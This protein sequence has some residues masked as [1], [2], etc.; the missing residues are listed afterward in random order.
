M[1]QNNLPW[2]VAWLTEAT[3]IDD[4]FVLAP[5]FKDLPAAAAELKTQGLKMIP[6]INAHLVSE[7]FKDKYFNEA[8]NSDALVKSSINPEYENGK[9]TN[10][11][12]FNKIV[13][14]DFFGKS[15]KS[16][17]QE[18]IDDFQQI[19]P[20]DGVFVDR[21][22]GL[23]GSCQGECPVNKTKVVTEGEINDEP[24]INMGWWSGFKD[25]S[26]K[27]TYFLPYVPGGWIGGNVLDWSTGSM[28]G[29]FPTGNYSVYDTH[30]L[31]GHISGKATYDALKNNSAFSDKLPFVISQ[32]SYAGSGSY[33]AH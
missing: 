1:T 24:I 27:S 30:N 10:K 21:N 13:Y 8:L 15:A 23:Y 29:T 16:V 28:N 7:D 22:A 14:P 2:E 11:R 12:G 4:N 26:V 17:W 6:A 3:D 9:L 33:M 25:Q 18:G 31:Y 5:G 32:G 20:F 19:L